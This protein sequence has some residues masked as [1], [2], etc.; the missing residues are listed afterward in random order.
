MDT[1][2]KITFFSKNSIYCP[3]CDT[4]FFKEEL[5]S[6]GG[7]LVAGKLTEELRRLYEPSKKFGEVFP[8]IYYV[9][10]C[11]NCYYAAFPEDF[12]QLDEHGIKALQPKGI[13]RRQALSLLV[14]PVNFSQPRTLKEGLAS[15]FLALESY[16]HFSKKN[17]PTIKR[18][19][20]ALRASWLA[21]DLHRKYPN[22]NYDYL[23]RLFY[24]K[25]HFF[26]SEAMALEQSGKETLSE[27][28]NLGPDLDKNYGYD[29]VLYIMGLLE[30]HY[31]PRK[32][33][34]KRLERL[35]NIKRAISKSHGIGK[36]SKSKPSAILDKAKDLYD[37]VGK[38][39]A[40]LESAVR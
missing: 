35:S 24:R 16:E 25:A 6:G 39:I 40:E 27:A 9:V 30:F 26:Y 36:A 10:V 1:D 3:L 29:G 22:E 13:A 2:K 23:S 15:Y 28:R 8:L 4:K 32:N 31:G 11:P 17:A 7:R 38:E 34:L 12:T 20:A 33:P 21:Q 37:E 19:I 18:G 5:F 14:Q